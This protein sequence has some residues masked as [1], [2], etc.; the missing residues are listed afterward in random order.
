MG[1]FKSKEEKAAAKFEKGDDLIGQGQY[2]K[3]RDKLLA[4]VK[5]GNTSADVKI[6]IAM[7]D[8]KLTPSRDT[9]QGLINALNGNESLT[10][11][12][13][14]HQ[15]PCGTLKN[16]LV[17][18]LEVLD[19]DNAIECKESYSRT[20]ED[21][22]RLI[23]AGNNMMNVCGDENL[24]HL[25][26]FDGQ[27]ITGRVF[28]LGYIA[29]GYEVAAHAISW[30]D[31]KK[32]AE[33]A[34]QAANYR[35]EENNTSMLAEDEKFVKGTSMTAHCW[36]CGKEVTGLDIHFVPMPSFVTK[37]LID[38]EKREGKSFPSYSGNE[39]YMCRACF[40]AIDK[41]DRKYFAMAKDY[42]NEEVEKLF[43]YTKSEVARLDE[44]IDDL[45][46]ALNRSR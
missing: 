8:Y 11:R 5:K 21:A 32:G 28:A 35:K 2:A 40:T 10:V 14:A 16:E 12:F 26:V 34:Q 15:V 3:A 6:L 41:N 22:N 43:N 45:I 42:T 18:C 37:P 27:K 4:S 20:V 7:L 23:Q 13:G 36:F 39:I 17:V 9:H 29:K 19:A 44:R 30:D 1:L 24:I 33:Y 31:P 25:A 46:D 38:A